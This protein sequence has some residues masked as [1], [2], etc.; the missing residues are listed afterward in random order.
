LTTSI[1]RGSS[2]FESFL[3]H[4]ARL[5]CESNKEEITDDDDDDDGQIQAAVQ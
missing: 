1:V 5:K 4:H 3:S 2:R